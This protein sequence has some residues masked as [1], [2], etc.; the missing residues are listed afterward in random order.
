MTGSH[1][2]YDSWLVG[3][4]ATGNI[5]WQ[6]C[7]GGTN[8]DFSAYRTIT[9]AS[10]TFTITLVASGTQPT[11]GQHIRVINYG[12]GL[13]TIARSG[14]NIN[15]A[16]T[17]LTLSAASGQ[18]PASAFIVSD[19]T[20]YLADV[21]GPSPTKRVL[22]LTS[23]TTYAPTTDTDQV[24]MA[25][26]GGAGTLTV[27]APTGTTPVNGQLLL[28]G[29]LCTNSQT[30]SW[31]SIY[32]PSPNISTPSVCPADVTKWFSVGAKYS[33]VLTKWQII[34]TN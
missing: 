30:F 28:L 34:A 25:M 32:I 8:A 18:A 24:E 7:N 29:F 13:V 19:G 15:G 26:T 27:N 12:T 33:S 21:N 1:G 17:S 6:K 16:T 31:N 22:T 5:Q 4:S 9:V 3:L 2:D 11:A 20:N 23:S 14:Q 10:G